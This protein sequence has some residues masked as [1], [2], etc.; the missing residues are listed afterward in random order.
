MGLM[1]LIGIIGLSGLIRRIDWRIGVV[2]VL[3][4]VITWAAVVS[5]WQVGLK[6]LTGL[7]RLSRLSR[8]ID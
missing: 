1:M 4:A 3:A 6:G 8:H 7:S 2:M 5:L